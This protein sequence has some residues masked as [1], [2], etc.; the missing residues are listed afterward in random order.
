MARRHIIKTKDF[1]NATT[2]IKTPAPGLVA[3]CEFFAGSTWQLLGDFVRAVTSYRAAANAY[4][5]LKIEDRQREALERCE[6]LLALY[7]DHLQSEGK[8]E[9][10]IP[11]LLWLAEASGQLGHREQFAAA[12]LNAALAMCKT[13]SRWDDARTMAR[14][15]YENSAPD[16]EAA[17]TAQ[18]LI[19]ECDRQLRS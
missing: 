8:L 7:T 16:S 6:K 19:S 11:A 5:E 1:V 18:A 2:R 14:V 13:S 3:E 12:A 9:Q 17:R 4:A 10:A 15:A